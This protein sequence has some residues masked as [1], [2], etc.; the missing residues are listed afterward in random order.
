MLAF[1]FRGAAFFFVDLLVFDTCVFQ[2]SDF[3]VCIFKLYMQVC[4]SEKELG[5]LSVVEAMIHFKAYDALEEILVLTV[6]ISDF[7]LTE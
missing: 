4:R 3:C 7:L 2:F 1:S 6:V 5:H